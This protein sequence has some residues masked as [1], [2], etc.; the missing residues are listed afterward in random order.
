MVISVCT[1]P[2]IA[3]STKSK[4][5][6][7]PLGMSP[8]S[9][10]LS[11]L[12]SALTSNAS[13]ALRFVTSYTTL[14]GRDCSNPQTGTAAAAS[15]SLACRS[16]KETCARN[17]SAAAFYAST[18]DRSASAE[19]FAACNWPLSTSNWASNLRCASLA[20]ALALALAVR[21]ALRS[22]TAVITQPATAMAKLT[23]HPMTTSVVD[24]VQ[25]QGS[26]M[27]TTLQQIRI[28]AFK[29]REVA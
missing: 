13:K 7:D 26:T 23:A 1:P 22:L 18:C 17:D 21:A 16:S 3:D 6:D 28:Q 29:A 15:A 25:V 4:L 11:P 27:Y 2:Q 8:S 9:Y 19:S 14:R 5:V 20:S 24:N 10:D 12:Y